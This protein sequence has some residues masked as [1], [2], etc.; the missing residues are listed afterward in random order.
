MAVLTKELGR[1][2]VSD[3]M[4]RKLGILSDQVKRCKQALSVISASAGEARAESG[5]LIQVGHFIETVAREWKKQRLNA[6]L[7]VQIQP[8]MAQAQIVD[9]YTLHQSLINLLNNAADASAEPLVMTAGW[10]QQ[11]MNIDILDRGPGLHPHTASTISEHKTSHKEFGMGLGLFLTH[12]TLQRLG[13][14]IELFDR[15]GGGTCTRVQLP[16]ATFSHS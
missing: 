6:A 16:L 1:A 8:G 4:K 9:E 14:K 3:A 12:A 2:D 11:T 10:D 13:G 15:E 7:D 5:S